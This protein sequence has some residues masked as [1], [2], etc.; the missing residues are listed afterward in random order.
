M[1][2][3]WKF[4]LVKKFSLLLTCELCNRLLELVNGLYLKLFTPKQAREVCI[5]TK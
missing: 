3:M 4:G 1:P 2:K 5:P